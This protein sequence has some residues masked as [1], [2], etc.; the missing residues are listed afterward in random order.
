MNILIT[1]KSQLKYD[2]VRKLFPHAQI[3]QISVTCNNPNQPINSARQCALNRIDGL[4][5]DISQ[6]D[7]IISLENGFYVAYNVC[8]DVCAAVIVNPKTKQT[9]YGLSFPI[10]VDRKY[11]ERAVEKSK[12]EFN[13]LGIKYTI[14]E[15]IHEEFPDIPADN[16]MESQCFGN[17]D[18]R[19]QIEDAIKNA[20]DRSNLESIY[21]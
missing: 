8:E 19:F 5:C 10:P 2:A 4:T 9:Y 7:L 18:R 6:Y 13:P 12:E 1:S 20:I 17:V 15:M 11:Y 16:W 14:G 21:C 3:T